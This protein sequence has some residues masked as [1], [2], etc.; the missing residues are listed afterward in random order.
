VKKRGTAAAIDAMPRTQGTLF[1]EHQPKACASQWYTPDWLATRIAVW[2]GFTPDDKLLEPAAG[3]GALIRPLPL[4]A[5]TAVELDEENAV[6]LLADLPC[7]RLT[8]HSRDF[9]TCTPTEL[10]TF[11]GVIMNPP[12]EG[13]LDADFVMHALDFAPRVIALLR[14]AFR[15]GDHRWSRVWKWVDCPR[16]AELIG[17]PKFGQGLASNTPMSDFAV[18]EFQRR[19]GGPHPRGDGLRGGRNVEVQWW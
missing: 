12:Y 11:D 17:R 7:A 14:S 6:A 8:A 9:L 15:H 13:N 4:C 2:S 3:R 5:W 19:D 16:M 18:F 10:G 1:E